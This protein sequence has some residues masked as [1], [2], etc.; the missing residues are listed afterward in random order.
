MVEQQI[1]SIP[2][3]FVIRYFSIN[4]NSFLISFSSFESNTSFC[5]YREVQSNVSI[6]LYNTV[7]NIGSD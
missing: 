7:V 4:F 6:E 2:I 5:G 3:A 1:G